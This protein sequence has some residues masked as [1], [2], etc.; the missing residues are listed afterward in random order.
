VLSS[1]LKRLGVAL[2]QVT[3]NVMAAAD[4]GSYTANSEVAQ[5]ILESVAGDVDLK[6][7]TELLSE[8]ARLTRALIAD[9]RLLKKHGI[10]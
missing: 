8:H 1:K 2:Q 10:Q 4:A 6:A 5:E 7:I 3:E 9:A